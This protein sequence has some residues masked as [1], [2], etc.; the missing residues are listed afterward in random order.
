MKLAD[1]SGLAYK[2]TLLN[3]RWDLG[4]DAIRVFGALWVVPAIGF[5]VAAVAL[6]A[7]LDWWKPVL[8]PVTLFSLALTSLDWSSAFMGAITDMAIVTLVWLG[9]PIARWIS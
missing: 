7:G 8:V 9:P 3:G 4:E 6:V 5:V 2:T 1:V